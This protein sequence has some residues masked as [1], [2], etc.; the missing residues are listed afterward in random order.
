MGE[1]RGAISDQRL[2]VPLGLRSFASTV[3]SPSPS[4]RR[5]IDG[6]DTQRSSRVDSVLAN[7]DRMLANRSQRARAVRDTHPLATNE[8]AQVIQRNATL[9]DGN[10][11]TSDQGTTRYR[12]RVYSSDEDGLEEANDLGA[13]FDVRRLA[14]LAPPHR[15]GRRGEH[16][17]PATVDP[18]VRKDEPAARVWA[19]PPP[20]LVPRKNRAQVIREALARDQGS[21]VLGAARDTFG[22][23]RKE[24]EPADP[25]KR[26]DRNHPHQNKSGQ[27]TRILAQGRP[28]KSSDARANF[29]KFMLAR[30]QVPP[31]LRYAPHLY[32]SIVGFERLSG[33]LLLG[34]SVAVLVMT[35]LIRIVLP[36]KKVRQ[37]AWM[38]YQTIPNE[39]VDETTTAKPKPKLGSV[40]GR[41]CR[42]WSSR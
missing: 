4:P 7:R 6:Q 2:N 28:T 21:N 13:T 24:F 20:R 8:P 37:H 29:T 42:A 10:A 9:L 27:A 1:P 23:P 31:A 34:S 17:M 30:R 12:G 15:T 22:R 36:G 25:E 32:M 3:S 18:P 35:L 40:M 19:A 16:R 11:V 14:D 39:K 38:Q 41:F 26:M 5:N 33:C